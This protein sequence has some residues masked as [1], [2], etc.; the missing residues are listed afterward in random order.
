MAHITPLRAANLQFGYSK[1]CSGIF[2]DGE[3]DKGEVKVP[4]AD[5]QF[6]NYEM[7]A[8]PKPGDTEAEVLSGFISQ[9]PSLKR[10]T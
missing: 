5:W 6:I 2:G 1:Q 10:R 9:H 8:Q 4:H 3:N 7:K